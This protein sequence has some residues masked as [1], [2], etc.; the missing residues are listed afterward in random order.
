VRCYGGAHRSRAQ[1]RDPAYPVRH[2]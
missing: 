2:R 1:D